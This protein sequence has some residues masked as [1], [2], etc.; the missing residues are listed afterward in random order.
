MEC[1]QTIESIYKEIDKFPIQFKGNPLWLLFIDAEPIEEPE[2][3]LNCLDSPNIIEEKREYLV[4]H[5]NQWPFPT[6]KKGSRPDPITL[7]NILFN[8]FDFAR[9]LLFKQTDISGYLTQLAKAEDPNLVILFI[10]DGL[11]YYDLPDNPDIVPCLVPGITT[12]EHGFANIV[13]KPPLG[14]RLFKLGYLRQYGYTYFDYNTNSLAKELF[15]CFSETV[16]KKVLSFEEILHNMEKEC[17]TKAFI[18]ITS[19]GLDHICHNHREPPPIEHYVSE[20]TLRYEK[21]QDLVRSLGKTALICLVADHGIIWKNKISQDLEVM[22][23]F[24]PEDIRSPRFLRGRFL[25]NHTYCVVENGSYSLLQ[26]PFITKKLRSNEW[27]VHGGI[28][29]FE[30]IVPFWIKRITKE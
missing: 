7:S 26:F 27:G 21:L 12:T 4:K 2:K 24:L 28:S 19:A 6:I 20:I 14:S 5:Y 9:R 8:R 11:S 30:S 25:R 13:G 15:S 22:N 16:V 18:Q 17:P 3:F 1:I 23:Q 10:V 29:A